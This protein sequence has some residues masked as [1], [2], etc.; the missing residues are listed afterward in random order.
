MK[1]FE[2][3]KSDESKLKKRN[4]QYSQ[5]VN[6]KMPKTKMLLTCVRAFFIGGLICSIGQVLLDFAKSY[7][8][9]D[10]QTAGTFTSIVLIFVG[11]TLTGLGVYDVI[12][13]YAG[14]GSIVP[15]TGFANSIV[16]PA[17]EHKRE[18]KVM[19]VGANLFK[20]AGPVL[21]CG[22]SAAAVY[23]LIYWLLK[24]VGIV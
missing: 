7:L 12:G 3:K 15:I 23:G 11:A 10:K 21:V 16:A 17:M 14:A 24:V 19:G 8:E 20:L 5:Y 22:I 6:K 13:K 4:N 18:G 2:A 1:S 9:M